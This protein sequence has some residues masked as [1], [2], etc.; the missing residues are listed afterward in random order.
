MPIVP[1]FGYR[2]LLRN[3]ERTVRSSPTQLLAGSSCSSGPRP[4][5]ASQRFDLRRFTNTH[6]S[7][8]KIVLVRSNYSAVIMATSLWGLPPDSLSGPETPLCFRLYVIAAK[9]NRLAH[10]RHIIKGGL[11]LFCIIATHQT[12]L[13]LVV[14]TLLC[15]A[16]SPSPEIIVPEGYSCHSLP[17]PRL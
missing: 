16:S 10:Q 12:R 6:N 17:K 15:A 13:G 8:F 3:N 14:I 2:I 1:P 11:A 4:S 9:A 5:R 7:R